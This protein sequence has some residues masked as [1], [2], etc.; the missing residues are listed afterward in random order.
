MAYNGDE[1]FKKSNIYDIVCG[2]EGGCIHDS[3]SIIIKINNQIKKKNT[4]YNDYLWNTF[5]TS[6]SRSMLF[7]KLIDNYHKKLLI[8]K[9]SK[10][11][12]HFI[13]YCYLT[14]RTLKNNCS[15]SEKKKQNNNKIKK[16]HPT[17]S[18]TTSI[19][20]NSGVLADRVKSATCNLTN[21]SSRAVATS[22]RDTS[23]TETDFDSDSVE[24]EFDNDGGKKLN[25]SRKKYSSCAF[26]RE[27][28]AS[29]K[30]DSTSDAFGAGTTFEK[31]KV[32]FSRSRQCFS[33]LFNAYFGVNLIVAQEFFK[34]IKPAC[35][36]KTGTYPFDVC[37]LFLDYLKISKLKFLYKF[38][39]VIYNEQLHDADSIKIIYDSI[40][41]NITK[42]NN[43]ELLTTPPKLPILAYY[44]STGCETVPKH[45]CGIFIDLY[46][47]VYIFYNSLAGA[48]HENKNL[49]FVLKK[50]VYNN[51]KQLTVNQTCETR[52]TN[53]SECDDF[54]QDDFVY[55]TNKYR[56]QGKNK[57]C[58]LFVLRFFD[59]MAKCPERTRRTQ[60]NFFIENFGTDMG[61]IDDFIEIKQNDYINPCID[62]Q[63]TP[64]VN[65]L[66][67]TF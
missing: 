63:N 36:T 66:N 34:S 54:Q 26:C 67:Q 8:N 12:F 28:D 47:G 13:Y 20:S 57:L 5:Y 58:G 23:Y 48:S 18:S 4:C 15:S 27:D 6:T 46:T 24:E 7:K 41:L 2:G 25:N 64:L 10:D 51:N 61:I 11:L 29:T 42:N 55:A 59:V 53:S 49:Y 32:F 3:N 39:G 56:H 19:L 31:F 44:Y 40:V 65:F 16:H 21:R 35:H 33:I 22:F 52:S 1:C 43:T 17:L 60:L 45:W 37:Q 50:L 62:L 38:M 14:I 9:T 30:Y